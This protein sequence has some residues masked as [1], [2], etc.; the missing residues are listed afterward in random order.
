MQHVGPHTAGSDVNQAAKQSQICAASRLD[1][2]VAVRPL[3]CKI[4]HLCVRVL[5]LDG[6]RSR[7]VIAKRCGDF[8]AEPRKKHETVITMPTIEIRQTDT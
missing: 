2:V 4:F 8:T 5:V 6:D 1:L 3:N 7:H